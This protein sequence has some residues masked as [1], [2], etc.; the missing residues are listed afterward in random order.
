MNAITARLRAPFAALA[1]RRSG[2]AAVK[3]LSELT[4]RI[5]K[6]S[7][8]EGLSEGE[9]IELVNSARIGVSPSRTEA[10]LAEIFAGESPGDIR[11]TVAVAHELEERFGEPLKTDLASPLARLGWVLARIFGT[12]LG[13]S[14][15]YLVVGGLLEGESE[16]FPAAPGPLGLFVFA[17]ALAFLGLF[18]A[19]HTSV[20]QLR[21]AD[22]RG[23]AE[24]YPRALALHR[25]FRDE[26]GISRVLAGR[27]IVVVIRSFSS[28]VSPAFPT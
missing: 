24:T 16:R 26:E 8:L 7:R 9:A 18:E 19:L 14:C 27:Q 2:S 25:R 12:A 28:P 1:T 20:T 17:F 11:A 5:R 13:V 15:T 10:V 21:L 3:G 23:V 6:L 22:L 4:D